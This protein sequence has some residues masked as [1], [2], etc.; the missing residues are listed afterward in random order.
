MATKAPANPAA[1]EYEHEEAVGG[2]TP[3]KVAASSEV[4]L[5]GRSSRGSVVGSP[6]EV[7]TLSQDF[8][9]KLSADAA[10]KAYLD[11]R[12]NGQASQREL[13]LAIDRLATAV[14]WKV[15]DQ[16]VP[17]HQADN[18]PPSRTEEETKRRQAAAKK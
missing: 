1:K 13:D 16:P 12:H 8:T 14:G 2:I 9:K 18:L 11:L 10:I 5:E 4:N 7:I 15:E 3:A 6:E 17:D